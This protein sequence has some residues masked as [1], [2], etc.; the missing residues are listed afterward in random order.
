MQLARA[1][2]GAWR[3]ARLSA[4]GLAAVA[5]AVQVADAQSRAPARC[6][7]YEHSEFRGA[8]YSFREGLDI[9]RFR[10]WNDRVSSVKVFKGCRFEMFEHWDYQGRRVVYEGDLSY[11][12]RAMNDRFSSAR[13]SCP[14]LNQRPVRGGGGQGR[15]QG[16]IETD[17]GV[18]GRGFVA[19]P[20]P[21]RGEYACVVHR[22]TNYEGGWRAFERSSNTYTLGRR[23]TDGIRSISVAR[24]CFAI[25]DTGRPFKA[26]F[27]SS[28]RG[29]SNGAPIS[30]KAIRCGCF[31]R[32]NR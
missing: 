19:P 28:F 31:P 24:G 9:P 14:G 5:A 6:T 16:V 15:G 30:A 21:R 32:R 22:R 29:L 20:Q 7:M 13:C 26:F 18:A 27:D 2:A 4:L 17:G 8:V 10:S 25:V 3:A 1:L 11:V 23:L 12:G